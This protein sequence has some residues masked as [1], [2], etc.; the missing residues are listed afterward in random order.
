MGKK[1]KI[2]FPKSFLKF[3]VTIVIYAILPASAV[4]RGM[5]FV[6]NCGNLQIPSL[7]ALILSNQILPL[8]FY[9][10]MTESFLRVI[11]LTMENMYVPEL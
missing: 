6:E 8:T 3:R 1:G 4:L 7:R 11:I 9:S 10:F 2:I 5:L